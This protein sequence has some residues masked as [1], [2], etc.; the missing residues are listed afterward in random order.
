MS[1][2]DVTVA[3][4]WAETPGL[5]G[6][7]LEAGAEIRADHTVPG[8]V[9]AAHAPDGGKV[10]LALS[11]VPGADQLE[12]LAAPGAVERLG[13]S[14]GQALA[15]EGPFGQGF[16]LAPA[17]GKDILLFAVGS[18][19]AP[20]RPVVEMIRRERADFGQ[21]TL[22]VGAMDEKAFAYHQDY[23]GWMRDRVDVIKVTHPE[24]VQ[25]AFAADPLPVDDAIAY[26]CG[27]NEMM[28]G[29]TETL[30]RFGLAPERV[31]RNW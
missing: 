5:T 13:L 19:L 23:D 8:Q 11:S 6:V 18:A 25:N 24:F 10:Y 30:G 28:D 16:P 17:L 20:I 9:L 22:Y 14:P 2:R 31:L 27:M 12:L 21:V 26:V 29:V 1:T 3:R 15:V 4:V 7:R